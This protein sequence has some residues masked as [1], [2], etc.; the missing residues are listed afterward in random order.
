MATD[1]DLSWSGVQS[2]ICY[3]CRSRIAHLDVLRQ[4]LPLVISEAIATFSS[5]PSA[6]EGQ[7]RALRQR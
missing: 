3:P 2:Y 7:T 5:A 4:H 6:A 1:T